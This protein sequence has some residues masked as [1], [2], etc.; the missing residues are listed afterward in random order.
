[1]TPES[2]GFLGVLGRQ[3]AFFQ[4]YRQPLVYFVRNW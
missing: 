3:L 1:M 2:L 4:Y